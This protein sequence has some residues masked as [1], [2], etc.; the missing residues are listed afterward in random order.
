MADFCSTRANLAP[1]PAPVAPA[2]AWQVS[3]PAPLTKNYDFAL[4]V[5]DQGRTYTTGSLQGPTRSHTIVA[6]DE[7]GTT[8]W[9][10]DLEGGGIRDFF[11]AADGTIHA[12][13]DASSSSSGATARC[14]RRIRSR[15]GSGASRWTRTGRCI[16]FVDYE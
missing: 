8:A 1:G 15:R 10:T 7:D 11:L 4:V 2:V 13:L 3:L 14:R 16:A 12:H 5:D 6:I 9:T